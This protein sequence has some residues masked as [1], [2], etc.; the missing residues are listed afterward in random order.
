VSDADLRLTR[1]FQATFPELAIED[2]ASAS[3][4][5]VTGWDSLQSV[6]LIAVLEEAFELRIAPDD[7]PSL[8][9]YSSVREYLRSA[10]QL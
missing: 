3:V 1:C 8:R 10:G 9:S 5:T 2:L 7:Y 6:I 4:D